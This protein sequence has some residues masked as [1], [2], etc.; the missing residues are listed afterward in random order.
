MYPS[1]IFQQKPGAGIPRRVRH[2]LDWDMCLRITHP[3][4]Y[5]KEFS[6]DDL[7][8]CAIN[9]DICVKITTAY[10][11]VPSRIRF[12]IKYDDDDDDNNNNKNRHHKNKVK[13]LLC[14][15]NTKLPRV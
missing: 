5:S 3:F 4:D 9:T 1:A 11:F 12:D 15:I 6:P 13:L 2:R 8:L 14:L 10:S 7:C